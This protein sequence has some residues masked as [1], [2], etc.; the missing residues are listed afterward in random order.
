MVEGD[1]CRQLREVSNLKYPLLSDEDF[2]IFRF[3]KYNRPDELNRKTLYTSTIVWNQDRIYDLDMKNLS[4]CYFL[5]LFSF[6]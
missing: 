5:H 3:S 4:F 1:R 6:F 2:A